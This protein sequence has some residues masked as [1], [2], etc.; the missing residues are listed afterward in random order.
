MIFITVNQHLGKGIMF[1]HR[2]L[3][4]DLSIKKLYELLDNKITINLIGDL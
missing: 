4:I 3:I 2:D 1:H